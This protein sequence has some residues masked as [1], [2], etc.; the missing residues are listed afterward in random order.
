MQNISEISVEPVKGTPVRRYFLDKRGVPTQ[1]MAGTSG[2]GHYEIA[3]AVTGADTGELY[4]QMARLGFARVL[5]TT[6]EIHVE[7][8]N[9]TRKQKDYLLVRSRETGLPIIHNSRAFVESKDARAS[10]VVSHLLQ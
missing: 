6:E 5:E 7:C 1:R 2:K 10:A 4:G 3:Q 9:L 8:R